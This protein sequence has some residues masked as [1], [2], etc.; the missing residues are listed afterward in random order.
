MSKN[1]KGTDETFIENMEP[2]K[3]SEDA[4]TEEIIITDAVSE[5]NKK[6]EEYKDMLQRLQA[7]F[8]NFRKR[9]NDSIKIA[10]NDGLNE[11][12]IALLPVLDNF[13]RGLSIISDENI[14]NGMELIYKQILNIFTKY[15]VE[16]IVAIGA[17]F[18]PKY[19]HA[20]AQCEDAENS[21]K[22]VEVFQKGYKRKDKVL[23]PS[24]VKVAQ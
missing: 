5:A 1:K 6:V 7:E 18:D 20:I 14:K 21:N 4:E 9:N 10:R 23:R 3:I 13:E 12:V 22:V 16:E 24:M 15:D 8:D 17:E 19:H 11:I 2:I